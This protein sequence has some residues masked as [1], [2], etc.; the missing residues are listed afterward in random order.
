MCCLYSLIIGQ[1]KAALQDDNF[2]ESQQNQ[3]TTLL[4]TPKTS[5]H[6]QHVIENP[7][8]ET[9]HPL[10]QKRSPGNENKYSILCYHKDEG[11]YGGVSLH[12]INE[13]SLFSEISK[14]LSS[15]FI[16]WFQDNKIYQ[17]NRFLTKKSSD[18][19]SDHRELEEGVIKLILSIS[20]FVLRFSPRGMVV[21]T[22]THFESILS[23]VGLRFANIGHVRDGDSSNTVFLYIP[24]DTDYL[25]KLKKMYGYSSCE[26]FLCEPLQPNETYDP[27]CFDVALSRGI[28]LGSTLTRLQSKL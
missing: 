15:K 1:A 26:S 23:S 16:P 19:K 13:P 2:V 8:N 25:E 27:Q 3:T 24:A 17:M 9:S 4:V 14:Y 22:D 21:V 12:P 7:S 28:F 18:L 11:I 6:Y 20:E 10:D 5:P